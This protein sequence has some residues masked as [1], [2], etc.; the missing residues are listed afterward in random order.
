MAVVATRG[1]TIDL[2]PAAVDREAPQPSHRL[3]V[4]TGQPAGDD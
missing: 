2:D 1:K 3:G 4:R